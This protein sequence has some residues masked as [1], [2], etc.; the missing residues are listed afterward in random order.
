MVMYLYPFIRGG[1]FKAVVSMC[2]IEVEWYNGNEQIQDATQS[3]YHRTTTYETILT[4]MSIR[5]SHATVSGSPL[6]SRGFGDY[7]TPGF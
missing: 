6:F 3:V 7:Q 1:L 2:H 5:S 4:V